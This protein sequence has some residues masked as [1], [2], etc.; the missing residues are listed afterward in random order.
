MP[1]KGR[2][3]TVTSLHALVSLPFWPPRPGPLS[4]SSAIFHFSIDQTWVVVEGATWVC[5]LWVK[6]DTFLGTS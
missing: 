6:K 4:H 1:D 5:D 3:A 2:R